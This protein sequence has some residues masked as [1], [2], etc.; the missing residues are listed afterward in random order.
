MF[1]GAQAA[2]SDLVS[3]IR[4]L[5]DRSNQEFDRLGRE[6]EDDVAALMEQFESGLDGLEERVVEQRLAHIER[7]LRA[8]EK[9]GKLYGHLFDDV[10]T[11]K[12]LHQR[13]TNYRAWLRCRG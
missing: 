2:A 12:Y 6:Q 8:I 13:Y 10:L 5:F 4:T 1:A 3:W 9:G 7:A 11:L